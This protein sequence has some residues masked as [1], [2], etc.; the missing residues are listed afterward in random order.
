MFAGRD[1]AE[2]VVVVEPV[3]G[4]GVGDA[5]ALVGVQYISRSF[6]N[7]STASKNRRDYP[8]TKCSCVF[9]EG[10][11]FAANR[12]ELQPILWRNIV[13]KRW[14]LEEKEHSVTPLFDYSLLRKVR[15]SSSFR[16][17]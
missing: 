17:H 4:V 9:L 15:F 5:G 1:L 2:G 3:G 7:S 13:I 14:N 8:S 11:N 10:F 12:F 16:H 6:N